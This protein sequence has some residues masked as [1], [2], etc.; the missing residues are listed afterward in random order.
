MV[1]TNLFSLT[2]ETI[3]GRDFRS[4]ASSPRE[5]ND[6]VYDLITVVND[7]DIAIQGILILDYIGSS[8]N[9]SIPSLIEDLPVTVIGPESFAQKGIVSIQIPDSVLVILELAFWKNEIDG[10]LLIPNGVEALGFAAFA[11]NKITSISLSDGLKYISAG[12]FYGNNITNVNLPSSV[13]VMDVIAFGYSIRE[14]TINSTIEIPRAKEGV[15]YNIIVRPYE[16]AETP[17][18]KTFGTISTYG[19]DGYNVTNARLFEEA[20][21]RSGKQEGTYNRGQFNGFWELG[22]SRYEISFFVKSDGNDQNDGLTAET[23]FR[24]L[25]KAFEMAMQSNNINMIVIIG[26][27]DPVSEGYEPFE[28]NNFDDVFN[29]TNRRIPVSNSIF[30]LSSNERIQEKWDEEIIITGTRDGLSVLSG[31]NNREAVVLSIGARV[32]IRLQNITIEDGGCGLLVWG[33][34]VI[35]NGVLMSSSVYLGNNVNIQNNQNM[36]GL[37]VWTGGFVGG[38]FEFIEGSG[39]GVIIANGGN[40]VMD[41]D[42][43]TIGSNWASSFGGGMY[44]HRG[45]TTMIGELIIIH[46][47]ASFGGGV[48]VGNRGTFT[49]ESGQ[50]KGNVSAEFG[51]GVFVINQGRFIVTGSGSA[52]IAGNNPSL[53]INT[54]NAKEGHAV[55]VSRGENTYKRE[56][57]IKDEYFDSETGPW[58]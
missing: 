46:N 30:N 25:K 18:E 26:T 35:S 11:E 50:I 33:Q 1:C 31:G 55:F 38:N 56:T 51:G 7:E 8:K 12:V 14:I 44:I 32:N 39:G 34:S 27:L 21:S 22:P 15:T 58:E 28:Y 54:H 53:T 23:A 57:D 9:V 41:G 19:Y 40:L 48:F 47:M 24:T 6:F 43:S 16:N 42:W 4:L 29:L 52:Y 20:Y 37:A 17:G 45:S 36:G 13:L 5:T 2:I 3:V 10:H 49:M